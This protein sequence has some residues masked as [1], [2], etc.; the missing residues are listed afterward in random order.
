MKKLLSVVLAL[1]SIWSAAYAVPALR[2]P[3]TVTQ[4]DGSR[5]T[6]TMVGDEWHH[7]LITRDGKPVAVGTDGDLYYRTAD[8]ITTVRAHE[9]GDRSDAERAF[10]SQNASK[11]TREALVANS[12]RAKARAKSPLKVGSTQVPTSG[13]PKVPIILVEYSDKKMSNSKATF[14]SQYTSGSTS[15]YQ[16]FYDQSNGLYRPQFDVYGIYT[17]TKSRATYGGNDSSG[18][19]KGVGTMVADAIKAAGNDIDWSQYDNDGDGAADVC[20]VVYAGVGESQAYGIVPNAVWPCQWDLASSDYGSTI[21]R[22][23][24]TISKFAVFNEINGDDDDSTIID[25]VGTFC[26]EF[27]HCLGLPDFYD[28]DYTNDYGYYAVG[29]WSLMCSGCYNNNG[30]TP[31]GYSAYE[32]NFMGWIDLLNPTVNTQYTLPAL[33]QK[34]ASTDVAYKITSPL[35][36]NEY[37]VLENRA[38]QGWDAYIADEGMMVTRVTYVASRWNSNEVNNQST[39]LFTIIPANNFATSSIPT[40][41]VDESEHLFG[42]T[43]HELTDS[44]T[45]AAR[46]YM[47]KSGSINAG[48][49]GYME[50]PLTD[51]QWNS[52]SKD[53]T[54]WYMKGTSTLDAPVATAAT[55]VA[56]N[57]FTANWNA[58]AD[59]ASYDLHVLEQGAAGATTAVTFTPGTVNGTASGTTQG[60]DSMTSGDV[61]VATTKGQFGRTSEYRLYNGGE[62]TISSAAG[63]IT[64]IEF[65][66][67][68]GY[69][70]ANIT[71]DGISNGV[72]EGNASTVTFAVE[73]AQVRL[74]SIVVTI[75]GGA[76]EIEG[77]PFTT[78]TTTYQVTGL[79]ASTAYSY[80]VVANDADGAASAKSNSIE[81][82]TLSDGT[83]PQPELPTAVATAATAV[84]NDRFTANWQAIENA[85][86]Y[87]LSVF[88]RGAASQGSAASASF[89][90][91][92]GTLPSGVEANVEPVKDNNDRGCWWKNS[93]TAPVVTVALPVQ[94]ATV[95]SVVVTA[96]TNDAATTLSV[97]VGNT[98][99]GNAQ[100]IAS[101][102]TNKNQ[103]YTFTGNAS[104]DIVISASV[105]SGKGVAIRGIVVNYTTAGGQAAT[106]E[107]E[108]SPFTVQGTSREVTGLE[109]ST[110]YYYNVVALDAEG[111]A[112]SK[113]SNDI[114]VTTTAAPVVPAPEAAVA[115]EATAVTTSSFVANWNEAANAASY[116][117]YV[118]QVVETEAP[119][120]SEVLNESFA[121][122]DG[123]GGVAD[124][125]DT[126]KGTVAN[127]ALAS[128]EGWTFTNGYKGAGCVKL[129]A[130]KKQGIAVSPVL[131]IEGNATLTFQAGAW[132]GDATTIEVVVGNGEP[133]EVTI[134]NNAY[135]DCEVTL[136]G[137]TASDAVTIQAV[138]VSG[139]RFFL[140]NVVVTADGGEGGSIVETE[141]PL[142]G[143]N[144]LNV[145][146]T[147]QLVDGLQAGG[148]Y[149]YYVVAKNSVGVEAE[150]SDVIDVLLLTGSKG[151]L[152]ADGSVDGNDVSILLEMVLAGGVTDAQQA[153]A[154]INGD[155]SVD[156]NDV[157]ILLEMVLSGE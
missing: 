40:D 157:S 52:S 72:W 105:T 56:A 6:V 57:G 91:S 152:N 32:K 43:N 108:G 5:V 53:V 139:N 111:A 148:A 114:N 9:T 77:S 76:T 88:A 12:P 27:S 150:A 68:S 11:M 17:L 140:R 25:G 42:Q 73:N 155:G 10:L 93:G 94:G 102:L 67:Q 144:P 44:S 97:A 45:P 69:S 127:T 146:G 33:N 62:L 24:T 135:T 136:T 86:A 147:S 87:Q 132:N 117:L 19:D 49:S 65:T 51:I 4:S 3:T 125:T 81:V 151:D 129:G 74:S 39:Q 21:T 137:L 89:D 75:G 35:N 50:Q 106:V 46:L 85:A 64:K 104:G 99:Y 13:T 16:Y 47:T 154:D 100:S 80:Y 133:Q 126:W 103:E 29:Y 70:V 36:A 61:T 153:V 141:L 30:Y 59:A 142:E 18:N 14:V 2:K 109:A 123:T 121:E 138:N 96:S 116:D 95:T 38:K 15:A 23:S 128:Y 66:A 118:V 98:T 31:I 20:I 112:A 41:N 84:S 110:A 78:Q 55:A 120:V 124:D 63:D 7:T 145:Q 101:G 34:Q 90:L 54:F 26:H 79:A 37:Y 131:G 60:E 130:G 48:G 28:V 149:R 92:A 119:A 115:T 71:G 143:Y 82:T 113:V 8:G 156:G 22:N 122:V 134:V 1:I 83:E 58:V 107:I